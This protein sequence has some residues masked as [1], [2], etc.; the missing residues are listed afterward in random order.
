MSKP[1]FEQPPHVEDINTLFNN[2]FSIPVFQRPYS[3]GSEEI[4]ELFNDIVEYFCNKSDEEM[5]IGTVYLSLN[6]Q[7]KTSI[8]NYDIIDGQQRIT[9]LSLALLMLYHKA[10]ILGVGHDRTITSLEGS[11]W[12]IIEGRLPNKDVPLM[13]S[14]GIEK[15]VVKYIFDEVFDNADNPELIENI[16]KHD[17]ENTL[18]ER[19]INNLKTIIKNIE[20]KVLICDDEEQNA[21]QLLK[22]IDFILNNLKFI[23][24]TVD[25]NDIK[26]LF[27]IFESINSKGKQLDQIDLIKSYIFQ[28]IDGSDY[29]AYL[30]KWGKLIKE[31][32]DNLEDYMYIFVKAFIKYYKVSISAKYFR[33]M[34]NELMKYYKK[35]NLSDALKAFLD[36]MVKKVSYYKM[37]LNK[38]SFIIQNVKFKFF[39][40][41]INLLEYEHPKALIFRTYCEFAENEID[42][43]DMTNVIKAAFNYMFAFQ[44]I[45][46]RDSKDAIKV[47]EKIMNSIYSGNY[48]SKKIVK[49][50]A[51]SLQMEGIDKHN[52]KNNLL[53]FIG[54]SE[55]KERV[56][57]RVLLTAFEFSEKGKIDYDKGL[58]ILNNRD[59][60]QID[61][62]LPQT[63]EKNNAKC[64]YYPETIDGDNEVLRLKKNHDFNIPG[65]F[66]GIDYSLFLTQVLNK[67]GNLRLMWRLDNGEKSNSI[68]EL[69]DYSKFNKYCQIS[70]RAENIAESLCNNEIFEI[71]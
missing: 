70:S 19:I 56:A 15:N 58:Y 57:T 53:N 61:H 7:L 65:I 24:I 42:K 67:L 1:I 62:I 34:D 60:I 43:N 54:Y 17:C 10:K 33:T 2:C 52:I 49:E 29:N 71:I 37:L 64:F 35:D 45:A 51:T 32:E 25:K 59:A 20:D 48:D 27:E 16:L 9:T 30:S 21:S 46:N 44:T 13:S 38:N 5:F 31:T 12:K 39:T 14:G 4:N 69:K 3:W 63:P 40:S 55:R 47:F 66:D 41:C 28:N 6:M 11:L 22:F 23:A 18:E 26:R 50:F 8:N 36:D 68:V